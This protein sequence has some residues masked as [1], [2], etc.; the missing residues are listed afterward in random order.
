KGLHGLSHEAADA[1]HNGG[2]RDG[3]LPVDYVEDDLLVIGEPA[4]LV[5]RPPQPAK[6]CSVLTAE[7]YVEHLQDVDF[8]NMHSLVVYFDPIG[9]TASRN[10]T[11][12][13]S[14]SEPAAV[15]TVSNAVSA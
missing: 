11:C 2:G 3:R 13:M 9:L 4:G 15:S 5:F 14:T 7:L 12:T 6:C 8:V 1:G 10:T